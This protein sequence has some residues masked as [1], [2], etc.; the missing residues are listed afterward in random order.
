M[1]GVVEPGTR[2]A[3]TF[4]NCPRRLI[5]TVMAAQLKEAYAMHSCRQ[6][7]SRQQH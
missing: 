1:A 7:G 3:G 5:L 6:K 2:T 4:S